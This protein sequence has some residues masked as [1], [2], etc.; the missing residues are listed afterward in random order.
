MDSKSITAPGCS[1]TPRLLDRVRE[2]L[3]V[4]HYSLRTEE[5]YVCW[6]RRFIRFHQRHPREMG[7]AE[8]NSFLTDLATRG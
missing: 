1:K 3:R 7:P 4:R 2:E 6:V 8:I 5:A